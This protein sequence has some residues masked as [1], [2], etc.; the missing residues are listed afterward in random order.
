MRVRRRAATCFW[1]KLGPVLF[2]EIVRSRT[3]RVSRPRFY[4][5]HAII[6]QNPYARL[7]TERLAERHAALLSEAVWVLRFVRDGAARRICRATSQYHSSAETGGQRGSTSQD[8]YPR[9][10]YAGADSG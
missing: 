2:Q 3:G 5:A 4:A 1:R 6:P 7:W 10:C 8:R 9:Q